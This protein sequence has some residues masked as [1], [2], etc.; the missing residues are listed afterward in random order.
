MA[1][2]RVEDGA[3]ERVIFREAR[4]HQKIFLCDWGEQKRKVLQ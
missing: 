1:T 3:V 2:V 4:V